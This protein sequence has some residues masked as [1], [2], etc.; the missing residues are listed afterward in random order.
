MGL[1]PFGKPEFV[2]L[3]LKELIHFNADG[4]FQLNLEY[5]DFTLFAHFGLI[6][7]P[8]FFPTSDPVAVSLYSMGLLAIGFIAR[9][10]GGW[11]F[12]SIG[13]K[14]GRSKGLSLSMLGTL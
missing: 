10:L 2:D 14:Y 13:D 4:S 1:A 6:I 11:I 8:L 7:A 12:G 3:I 5:F 9:P